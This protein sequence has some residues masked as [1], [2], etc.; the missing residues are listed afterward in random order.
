MAGYENR[1]IQSLS[2]SNKTETNFL[3]Y[4]A[5][6]SNKHDLLI[7]LVNFRYGQM[8][9]SVAVEAYRQE[10]VN[11]NHNDFQVVDC[12]LIISNTYDYVMQCSR[13]S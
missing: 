13:E 11:L 8:H 7:F 12:G 10:M 3:Y 6:H 4:T 2:Q 5:S 1:N 9:E